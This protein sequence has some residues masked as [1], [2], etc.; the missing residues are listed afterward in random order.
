MKKSLGART[1]IYPAP[2]WC[3]GTYD[4]EGKPN[5]MTAS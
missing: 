3:V 5:V 1:L 4:A 2:V